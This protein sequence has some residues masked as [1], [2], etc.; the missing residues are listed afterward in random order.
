MTMSRLALNFSGLAILIT[1]FGLFGLAS[2]AA[3]RRTKEIGVRKVHGA[4][5]WQIVRMMM[6]SFI[7]IFT[8]AAVIVIPLSYFV[9]REWLSAFHYRTSLDVTVFAT[10]LG[11]ILLVT[12]VS[13]SY[14]TVKAALSNP[15]KTLRYE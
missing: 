1:M 7:R 10:G 8:V 15:V 4:S 13:V 5:V 14:E 12:I 6:T 9:L 3:E 2:Y 11:I